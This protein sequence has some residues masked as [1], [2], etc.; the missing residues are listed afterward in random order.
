MPRSCLACS[1]PDRE[2]IDAALVRGHPSVRDLE[3]KYGVSRSSL[4]RHSKTC[5]PGVMAR[6]V[7]DREVA[8]VEHGGD[9]LD[10]LA[11]LRAEGRQILA[12]ARTSNNST[13]ALR[14]INTLGRLLELTG[15]LEGRIS[16]GTTVNVGVSGSDLDRIRI[17]I[18][19]NLSDQ[20]IRLLGA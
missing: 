3:A 13:A 18:L 10:Q 6:A 9:L 5:I 8:L 7:E 15:K 4:S 19:E 12:E 14:A 17:V 16:D 2:A 20:S 11:S 1:H